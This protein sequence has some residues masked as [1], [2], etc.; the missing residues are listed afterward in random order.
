[1]IDFKKQKGLNYLKQVTSIPPGTIYNQPTLV[2][3]RWQSPGDETAFQ[4][5][6]SRTS[7][8]VRTRL[9]YLSISDAIY[10]DASFIR[11][12]TASLSYQFPDRWLNVI[13]F[14]G[15]KFYVEAQNLFTITNYKGTN[16]ESQ[17]FYV[18]PP[19]KTIVVGMQLKF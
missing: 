10:S 2:L 19:L 16:P 5:F 4:K 11:L 6:T 9:S 14:S 7:G 3:N 15:G 8:T 12:K 13:H 18:L 17:N 1:M